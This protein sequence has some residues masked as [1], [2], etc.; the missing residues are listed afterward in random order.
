MCRDADLRIAKRDDL[1]LEI[2]KLG[3][4]HELPPEIGSSCGSIIP[5]ALRITF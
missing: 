2:C 1:A 5:E 3:L 4:V